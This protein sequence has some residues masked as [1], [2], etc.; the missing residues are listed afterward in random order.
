MCELMASLYLNFG[1]ALLTVGRRREAH[2]AAMRA[3]SALARLP[4]GG[5]ERFIA[6]AVARLLD[7]S[8][9]ETTPA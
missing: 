1:D 3:Q 2:D 4:E 6:G 7:R 9:P 5:Y 8:R